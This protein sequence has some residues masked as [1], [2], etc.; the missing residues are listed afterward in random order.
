MAADL[1]AGPAAG[2]TDTHGHEREP[3][4][5]LGPAPLLWRGAG[6]ALLGL[7]LGLGA[8]QLLRWSVLLLPASLVLGGGA[9]LAAWAAAIH[10]TGG[11]RFDDG[12]CD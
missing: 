1:P 12:G 2:A 4:L 6:L 3:W 11:E 7:G 10:I 9:V 8:V 5:T